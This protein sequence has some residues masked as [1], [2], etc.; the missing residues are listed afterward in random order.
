MQHSAVQQYKVSS[1]PGCNASE[2]AAASAAS[3][4]GGL[5]SNNMRAHNNEEDDIIQMQPA[6]STTQGAVMCP[7]AVQAYKQAQL[8]SEA[9]DET[10]ALSQG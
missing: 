4:G 7:I 1:Y 10:T 5:A 8:M 9:N 6:G 2:N 3:V